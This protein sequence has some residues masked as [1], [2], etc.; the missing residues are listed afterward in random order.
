VNPLIA[1]A[2]RL[3]P[4]SRS[5]T[6]VVYFLRLRSGIIYVGSSTDLGQRL[7]D[8]LSGQACRTTTLDPPADLLRVEIFPTFTAARRR[9]AQLKCWSRPKKKLSF[10]E[11][12]RRSAR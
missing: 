3:A 9:E 4:H 8:H 10:A 6:P 11:I 1:E 2:H 7:V 12:L 5:G